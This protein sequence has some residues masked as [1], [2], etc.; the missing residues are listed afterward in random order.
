MPKHARFSKAFTDFTILV[1]HNIF[2]TNGTAKQQWTKREGSARKVTFADETDTNKSIS[3]SDSI[4]AASG[5]SLT[6][7]PKIEE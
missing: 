7:L 4:I 2:G 3:A 5:K 6:G 1:Y